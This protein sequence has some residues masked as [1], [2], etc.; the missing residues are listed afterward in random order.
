MV[1]I[2]LIETETP[3]EPKRRHRSDH[4]V[5]EL[6]YTVEEMRQMRYE[7]YLMLKAEFEREQ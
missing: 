7:D 3:D 1:T 2:R 5:Q 4:E 6:P